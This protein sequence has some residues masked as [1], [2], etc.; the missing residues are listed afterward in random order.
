MSSGTRM[1]CVRSFAFGWEA[2]LDRLV[3]HGSSGLS[4]VPT[5]LP[6]ILNGVSG[7][8][9]VA[10]PHGHL[11]VTLSHLPH[12]AVAAAFAGTHPPGVDLAIAGPDD[13]DTIRARVDAREVKL[14]LSR[15]CPKRMRSLLWAAREAVS[16]MALLAV[17]G[18]VTTARR[19][20]RFRLR[21]VAHFEVDVRMEPAYVLAIAIP[22]SAV[23]D[24]REL[25]ELLASPHDGRH[26]VHVHRPAGE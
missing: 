17:A 8:P 25:T 2:A 9:L 14:L 7:Q 21:H 20:I 24:S 19:V 23:L 18:A 1:P 13:L 3:G 16:K 15:E 6:V 12:I 10:A 5:L 26:A 11:G 22:C 4:R